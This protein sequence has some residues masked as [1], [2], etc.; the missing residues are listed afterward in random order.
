MILSNF[1]IS[2]RFPNRVVPVPKFKIQFA[3]MGEPAFNDNILEVLELLPS[4]YDA[5]GLLPTLSTV[6][7]AGTDSFF[8]RLLK[9]K[10]ELYSE[11]FQLQ[12]SIHST[13]VEKRDWLIPIKK[14]DFPK[15]AEYGQAFYERRGRKITLNFALAKDVPLEPRVLEKHFSP[16]KFLIK[17]TP[18]NPTCKASA[19]RISSYIIPEIVDYELIDDLRARGYEVILSIGELEENHIGSNCG[20]FVTNYMREKIPVEGGY[21]YTVERLNS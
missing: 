9:I 19:N 6:A 10:K 13:D 15:I 11:K 16:E 18:V 12:F 4:L 7:P 5:P 3:R 8:D 20:Q 21:S 2:N 17:I 1:L 14:W